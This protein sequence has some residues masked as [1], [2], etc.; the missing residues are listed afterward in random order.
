MRLFSLFVSA[1]R[2]SE[3]RSEDSVA[4]W[5]GSAVSRPIQRF[6]SSGKAW[7][8]RPSRVT[9]MPDFAQRC[10]VE[11]GRPR[12]V[13]IWR[14]PFSGVEDGSGFGLASFSMGNLSSLL[15]SFDAWNNSWAAGEFRCAAGCGPI[16]LG[17]GTAGSGCPHMSC[18]GSIARRFPK[19][20]FWRI[21]FMRDFPLRVPWRRKLLCGVRHCV[22]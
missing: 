17:R 9:G 1:R 19:W 4:M 8:R 16:R 3:L 11:I 7:M 18:D 6:S 13:A 21:Y 5:T 14:Q 2:S 12:N 20:G 15:L 22:I 10:A